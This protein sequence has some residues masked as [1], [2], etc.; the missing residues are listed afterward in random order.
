MKMKNLYIVALAVF[1]LASCSTISKIKTYEGTLDRS[2][3]PGAGTAKELAIG[4]H[5]EFTLANGMKVYV[6]ENHKLPTIS[7]SLGFDID[8]I[9]EGK[10][11]GYLSV[12]GDLIEAGTK[13]RTKA[14]LDEEVDFMGASVGAYASGLFA[15]GL[16]KYNSKILDIMADMTLNPLMPQSELERKITETL[17]GLK[18]SET[19]A[20]AI[21]GNVK[22]MIFYGK[23]HPYGEF[24]TK[25]TVKAITLEDCKNHYNTYFKPNNALLT[26]VGDITLED[27][28]KLVTEKF[29][30]WKKGEV[31][32]H[33]YSAPA[34]PSSPQVYVINKDGAVQS[35]ISIGNTVSLK[36]GDADYEA[37]KVLNNIFGSG[38][39]GRL[40]QNL[41]EDKE[42]TYGA[43]GGVSSNKLVGSFNSSAKVRNSVTDSAVEQF[44][45]EI[46]RIRT[47][48]VIA[49]D[50]QN[51]KNYIAGT[52]AQG[53][54]SPRTIA[55]FAAAIDEYKLDKDYYKNYLKRIDAVTA[56][57]ILR[58][59][60]KYMTPNNINIVVVGEASE[61]GSKLERF[62]TVNYLDKE[63]NK[64]NAPGAIEIPEGV[65]GTTVIQNYITAIGGEEKIKAVKTLVSEFGMKMQGMDILIK[66]SQSAPNKSF[67]SVSIPAMGMVMQK[68]VFNGTKGYT[69]AQGKVTPM[70]AEAVLEAKAETIIPE[71]NYTENGIKTNLL[72]VKT[73]NGKPAYEVELITK[74]GEKS[75]TYFDFTTGLKVK[76]SQVQ[77]TPAGDMTIDAFYGDYKEV[78]G[79]KFPHTMKQEAGPQKMEMTAKSIKVNVKV[80]E[81]IYKVK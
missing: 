24:V 26:I 9:V 60:K 25:E 36:L 62:G 13:N 77:S 2:V 41:R 54:E 66:K 46:N 72:S 44:L 15:S 65:T 67:S 14:Q 63:G 78:G 68:S 45:Y 76:E 43:Y 80:D 56:D 69:E 7:Y 6:I 74:S 55:S 48:K 3:M 75:K 20:D 61:I 70:T 29:G 28:K 8:P 23:N 50:I 18:A 47:E 81:S 40:F 51:A 53:L 5:Q 17:T 38:F 32:T 19:D 79:V 27:A 30:N 21:M 35:N 64:V 12:T 52:F 31:P 71:L 16:S 22:G 42:Y 10:K 1:A 59:A 33:T 34:K 57:D 39:S 49:V 58:V 37:V 11:A 73:V 4:N